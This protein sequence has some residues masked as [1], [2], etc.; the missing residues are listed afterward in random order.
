MRARWLC[1]PLALIVAMIGLACTAVTAASAT[2]AST[3]A[4]ILS[5]APGG[6]RF[7]PSLVY[8]PGVLSTW[9]S[10]HLSRW[11]PSPEQTTHGFDVSV[12]RVGLTA[13]LARESSP[14]SGDGVLKVGLSLEP[15]ALSV[16]SVD[17]DDADVFTLE[18][19]G[20]P[21]TIGPLPSTPTSSRGPKSLSQSRNF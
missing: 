2:A 19:A 9:P 16:G 21:G 8:R 7:L 1:T 5:H 15:P 6:S 13:G 14:G 4:L 20:Q 11:E 17:F 10:V 12:L 3:R 18:V